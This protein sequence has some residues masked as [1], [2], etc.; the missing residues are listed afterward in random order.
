M[1]GRANKKFCIAACW[2]GLAAGI[3][4]WLATA[5]GIYGELTIT[6]TGSDYPMLAGNLAS[7]LVSSLI[8]VAGFYLA[9]EHYDFAETK[10]LHSK[11]HLEVPKSDSLTGDEKE[12]DID[13]VAPQ[14]HA[15]AAA[16]INETN[17]Q[18]QDA[19]GLQKAYKLAVWSSIILFVVLLILCVYSS[20]LFFRPF[21]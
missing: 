5:K 1:S 8:S 3:A 11:E 9:P 12:K 16:S 20:R 4:A 13:G 2:I 19:R 18:D 21:S 10:A 14:Q 15:S 6:T 17:A 7:L